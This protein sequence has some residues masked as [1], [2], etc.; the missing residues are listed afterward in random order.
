MKMTVEVDCTPDEARRFMGLPDVEQA[1]A[2]YVDAMTTAMQGVTGGEQLE[3]YAR[4]MAPMG[5]L[6]LK[7]FQNFI[8]IATQ[9]GLRG[10]SPSNQKDEPKA[11][12]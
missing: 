7:L 4:Q 3:R 2:L 9:Q 10:A 12:N 1:N 11:E 6:G 5:Q 8:D